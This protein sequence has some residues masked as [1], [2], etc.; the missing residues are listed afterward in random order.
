M[1]AVNAAADLVTRDS[2]LDV[3]TV[4]QALVTARP[5]AMKCV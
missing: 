3:S 1:R 4:A 2:A 5:S